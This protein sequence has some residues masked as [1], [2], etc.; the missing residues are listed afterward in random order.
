MIFCWCVRLKKT[1]FPGFGI[2]RGD[3][4]KYPLCGMINVD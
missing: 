1:L 3:L 4:I 2:W